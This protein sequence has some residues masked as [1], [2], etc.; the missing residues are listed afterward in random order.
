MPFGET[1]L[2][3]L[4]PLPPPIGD[5]WDRIVR[6]Y[7]IPDLDGPLVRIT[8]PHCP[9]PSADV[10]EDAILPSADRIVD[11]VRKTLNS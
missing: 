8:T 3:E 1:D 10:L 11:R 6:G 5:L 7:A 9:L 4:E 2:A